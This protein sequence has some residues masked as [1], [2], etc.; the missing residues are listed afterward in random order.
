[1]HRSRDC[2]V[3]HSCAFPMAVTAWQCSKDENSINFFGA[4]KNGTLM[5]SSLVEFMHRSR[6]YDVLHSCAFAMAVTAWQ[7]SK[8]ENSISFFGASKNGTLMV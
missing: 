2:D 7:C 6:D 3:L 8:D 5:V 1:M 4:S